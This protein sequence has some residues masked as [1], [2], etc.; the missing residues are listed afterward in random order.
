LQSYVEASSARIRLRD[1][2]SAS[3]NDWTELRHE[4]I[5][6]GSWFTQRNSGALNIN[7]EPLVVDGTSAVDVRLF[8][9]TN[10]TGTRSLLLMQGDN[11]NTA[12]HSLVVHSTGTCV[13]NEQGA[14]I[15]FRIE[16]DTLTSLFHVDASTDRIGI[17]TAT[18][19]YL[20][21]VNGVFRAVGASRFDSHLT[22]AGDIY[23]DEI[24]KT[25]ISVGGTTSVR[26][27]TVS[28]KKYDDNASANTRFIVKW[29]ISSSSYG[30]LAKPTSS[31]VAFAHASGTAGS[32]EHLSGTVNT[33]TYC[34]GVTDD[35]GTCKITV[36]SGGS[37]GGSPT[38]YFHCEVQGIVAQASGT[39]D[40]PSA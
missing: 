1:T 26:T 23:Q 9:T 39:V 8:R 14:N 25:A 33:P 5:G 7:I 28:V 38:V 34:I 6:Q 24:V 40:V 16:G 32:E 17:N 20:L 21:D 27:F 31:T 11:T 30:A 15:D 4:G 3:V 35:A 22:V 36:T 2:D 19:S 18:P 37:G 12:V 13:F 10:T 29:W